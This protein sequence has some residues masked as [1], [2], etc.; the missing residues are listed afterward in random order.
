MRRWKI[1]SGKK[2]DKRKI[3]RNF[4]FDLEKREIFFRRKRFTLNTQQRKNE[5]MQFLLGSKIWRENFKIYFVSKKKKNFSIEIYFEIFLQI[6]ENPKNFMFSFFFLL[7]FNENIF[8]SFQIFLFL[9]KFFPFFQKVS[10]FQKNL[11][12]YLT[13]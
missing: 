2:S 13:K 3:S 6:L 9:L 7:G 10:V 11:F 8:S 5:N 12:F 1:K 4:N